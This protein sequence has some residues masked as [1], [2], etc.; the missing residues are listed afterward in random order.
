MSRRQ[1]EVI[2]DVQYFALLSQT[3]FSSMYFYCN[4]AKT[5][6]QVGQL[7]G[8]GVGRY[9]DAQAQQPVHSTS[10]KC[11]ASALNVSSLRCTICG[12]FMDPYRNN[13]TK[14]A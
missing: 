8:L 6:K 5:R 7:A 12:H 13:G 9:D 1:G 2:K 10:G 14:R 11:N 3:A 4:N